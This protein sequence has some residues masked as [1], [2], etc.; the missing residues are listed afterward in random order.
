M[1]QI[2][3]NEKTGQTQLVDVPCQRSEK[4][5]VLVRTVASLVSAGTERMV[6]EF[7]QKN[8]IEKARA[9][10][11]L[12][13]QVLDKVQR[14]G[15]LN[16]LELVRNRLDQALALGY[17]SAGTVIAV[18]EDVQDFQIGDQVAC[19]GGGYAVHAEVVSV[20]CNLVAHMPDVVDFESA[21][22][23]T[24]GAIALHGVRLADVKLGENIA[25]V[26]LGLVGLLT[27]QLAKVA[28]CRVLG[29]DLNP[30]RVELA[31]QLGVDLTLVGGRRSTVDDQDVLQAA[32]AFTQ[33]HGLDAV[34]I[35]AAT[36]GNEPI[37]L[38]GTIARDRGRVVAVGAVGL[39]IPRKLYYGKELSFRISRSYGPGRYDPEYEE[40]GH[41]YPIGYVRWTENR[42]M[43]AFLQLLAEGKVNVHP[44]ITHRFPIEEAP[45]AYDLITG[46]T[47]EPFLGVLITYPEQPGLSHKIMLDKVQGSQKSQRDQS[48]ATPT[49]FSGPSLPLRIGLLGAGNFAIA[50]LLPAMK[51]ISGIEFI[52]VCTATGLSARHVGDKFGFRYCTTNENEI[53]GD[54][55][56]NTVVIAT[57]HHLHACQVIAALEAG[58]HVFVEKPLCLNESEL[59]AISQIYASRLTPHASRPL[60]MVGFNRRF[61]PM[62]QQLKAFLADVHEPLVM[63]YRVNAGYIPPDHWVHDPDQGGGRIIGEACH[64][65]DILTFLAGALPVQVHAWALPN[66]GRYRDDNVVIILEFADGSLG[67]ITY[68][69]N[70]DKSFPKERVEV[71][72]SG[73]VAVLDDFRRLELV[74]NGHRKVV[75]SRLRQDKGHWGEWEAFVAALRN[76][77][78][79]PIPF[80]DIVTTTLATFAIVESLRKGTQVVAGPGTVK[81]MRRVEEPQ[82]LER[83]EETKARGTEGLKGQEDS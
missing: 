43:Q 36:S 42:N 67:T 55:N 2:V 37:E 39:T 7:A 59:C 29:L 6:V 18:G 11:D 8:L 60:F 49:V 72:G 79:P 68:T 21:A 83:V 4:S 3:Q 45:K 20:P 5:R 34:L 82:G 50:T 32:H 56:I 77:A 74:H 25:V 9:R 15:L 41:D 35:T 38:A 78:L 61:A 10:P 73:V 58:K 14:E 51:K 13:R 44:L 76:G 64:F 57:R 46:K 63:H 19:A 33:G 66:K 40:K 28:G 22:F 80:K 26:G 31:Q 52:G 30:A 69:A 53:F 70:G 71:F 75:K 12:V 23:T 1:K 48:S 65:V 62:A 17:S 16:T 27:V 24:L 47:G 54:P 81:E